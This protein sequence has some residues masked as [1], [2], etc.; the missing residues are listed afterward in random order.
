MLEPIR[1]QVDA[2]KVARNDDKYVV[3]ILTQMPER[4]RSTNEAAYHD[5]Q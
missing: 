5:L 3:E 2:A 4:P 1:A